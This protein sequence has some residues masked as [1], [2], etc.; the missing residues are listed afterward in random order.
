MGNGGKFIGWVGWIVA[1]VAVVLAVALRGSVRRLEDELERTQTALQAQ[2]RAVANFESHLAAPQEAVPAAERPGETLGASPEEATTIEEEYA[3][4]RGETAAAVSAP[5]DL[6]AEVGDGDAVNDAETGQDK[7]DE[8]AESE[9]PTGDGNAR[10]ARVVKAQMGML[11]NMAYGQLFDELS[12]PKDVED[13][14]RGLIAEALGE[15]NIAAAEAMESGDKTA[16]EMQQLEDEAEARLRNALSQVLNAEE[17]AAWDEYEEYADQYLFENLLE[18]QLTM[19]ASGLTPESRQTVGTVFAEELV[20]YLDEFGHSDEPYTL[21]NFN[22]AQLRA[23]QHGLERLVGVLDEEQYGAAEGFVQQ[24][25]AM[26]EAVA[27]Q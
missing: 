21:D 9:A 20:V 8:E 13:E 11:A 16:K 12:L 5:A 6:E 19:L 27:K 3:E 14:V 26:F 2:E 23:L 10:R 22:A 4:A 1:V 18:G 25:E 17:L 7:A 15:Q 24:C